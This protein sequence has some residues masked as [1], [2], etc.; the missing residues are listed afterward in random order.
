ML[1]LTRRVVLRLVVAA[2]VS[3]ASAAA[4]AAVGVFAATVHL[5]LVFLLAL[6]LVAVVLEPDLHLRGGEPD[7]HGH[8]LTL[9]GRQV[10]LHLETFLQFVNLR[11]WGDLFFE[12]NINT[13]K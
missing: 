10:L 4:V 2:V 12:I 3:S 9:R 6:V 5:F 8:L 1:A 13:I 11:E 7:A